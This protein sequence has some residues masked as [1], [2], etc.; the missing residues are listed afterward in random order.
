MS[1]RRREFPGPLQWVPGPGLPGPAQIQRSW[2]CRRMAGARKLRLGTLRLCGDWGGRV[3]AQTPGKR[4]GR[5]SGE[6]RQPTRQGIES[7]ALGT[8]GPGRE[9]VWRP[10][11]LKHSEQAEGKGT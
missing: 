5:Q 9:G 3:P 8:A 7:R 4:S 11:E 2:S 1:S 6:E 10:L